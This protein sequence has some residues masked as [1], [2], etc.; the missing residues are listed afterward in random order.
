MTEIEFKIL[1]KD[2]ATRVFANVKAQAEQSFKAVQSSSN[3]ATFAM[4]NFNRIVQDAPYGFIGIAN[5]LNPLLESFQRLQKET[6]GTSLALKAMAG[7]LMG[8]AGLGVAL[9]AV[10]TAVVLFSQNQQKAASETKKAK[11]ETEE[12]TNALIELDKAVNKRVSDKESLVLLEAEQKK[13]RMVLEQYEKMPDAIAKVLQTRTASNQID[14]QILSIIAPKTE[15]VKKFGENTAQ[16]FV[17]GVRERLIVVSK[18]IDSLKKSLFG[19]EKEIAESTGKSIEQVSVMTSKQLIPS[20]KEYDDQLKKVTITEQH[21]GNW[22]TVWLAQQKDI[23][24]EYDRLKGVINDFSVQFGNSLGAILDSNA[25]TVNKLSDLW[26]AFFENMRNQM[27]AM[28]AQEMALAAMTGGKE[29]NVESGI[30][31]LLGTIGGSLLGGP[32]GGA[33]GG[34][35]AGLF[36]SGGV[37]PKAHNGMY[38]DAPQS[39]EFPII[40]RGGETIRTEQQEYAMRGKGGG[41]VVININ[42]P[43]IADERAFKRIVEQGMRKAGVSNV[44]NYFKDQTSMIEVS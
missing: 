34:F 16:S 1:A 28:A 10:S 33:I 36:H 2:E 39:K 25:E 6:G 32:I 20:L 22:L 18:Q 24:R 29:G 40:V 5:N 14:K 11:K 9:A 7:S 17:D 15:D 27:L 35:I 3:S 21:N 4:M 44:S 19:N 37:V 42:N 26:N 23:E 38:I 8:P 12:Y 43:N 13:L 41:T 31:R 30:K